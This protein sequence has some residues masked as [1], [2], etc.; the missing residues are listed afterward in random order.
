MG[1]ENERERTLRHRGRWKHAGAVHV[2]DFDSGPPHDAPENGDLAWQLRA[3][4]QRVTDRFSGGGERAAGDGVKATAVR[5]KFGGKRSVGDCG[6]QFPS[7]GVESRRGLE[8]AALTA[9]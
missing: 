5:C 6:V 8:E 9:A 2:Q 7:T 4:N 3:K 1:V